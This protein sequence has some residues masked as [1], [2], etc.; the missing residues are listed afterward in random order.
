MCDR[1][2][3]VCDTALLSKSYTQ[4]AL[5]SVI[6]SKIN[7]IRH[8]IETPYINNGIDFFDLPNMYRNIS[9]KSSIPNYFQKCR[10]QII[11]Y[12]YNKPIR[13]AMFNF[14]KLVSDL[15][16]KLFLVILDVACCKS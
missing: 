6:D 10:V 14:N 9:V 13:S 1:T 4:H 3:R 7:H 16:I 5:R 15:I 11:C 8:F 2:N 12:K